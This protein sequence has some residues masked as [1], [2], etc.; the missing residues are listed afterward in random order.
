MREQAPGAKLLYERVS[1]AS[2]LVCTDFNMREQIPGANF[3]REIVCTDEGSFT[4][5]M[6]RECKRPLVYWSSKITQEYVVGACFVCAG[7]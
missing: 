2:S 4:R 6:L 1:V 5:S 3:S 7:L